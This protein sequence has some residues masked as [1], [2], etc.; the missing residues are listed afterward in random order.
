MRASL[1]QDRGI[2]PVIG[3]ILML[4]ITVALAMFAASFFLGL[5][6]ETDPQP[7]VV[8][9]DADADDT[10]HRL[11]HDGG[12]TLDGDRLELQGALNPDAAAGKRLEDGDEI[13][14]YPI[15]E[16]ITVVWH[17]DNDE[18]YQLTTLTVE[19]AL[20]EPDEGCEWVEDQTNG[21]TDPI[22]I[23]DKVVNCDVQTADQIKVRN[24]GIVI[25]ETLS[26]NKDLDIDAGEVYGDATIETVIDVQDGRIRGDTTSE[27]A[28]VK[29]SNTVVEGTVSSDKGTE[30]LDGSTVEDSVTAGGTIDV[31]DGEI[32]GAATSEDEDV[33]LTNAV[34][35]EEIAAGKVIDVQDSR[36]GGPATSE[37]K[38]VTFTNAVAEGGVT[39]ETVVDL[40]DSQIGGPATSKT[41]NVKLSNT[42]AGGGVTAEKTA[43]VLDGTTVD[44]SVTAKKGAT[45]DDGTVTGDVESTGEGTDI[46]SGSVVEGSVT[47]NKIVEVDGSTIEGH[48][49]AEP[50]DFKCTDSTINGEDCGSYDP[51]DPD[52]W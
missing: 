35:E 28:N 51:K 3:A 18:S 23:D 6:D 22:T 12:E 2:S 7:N 8:L 39:A 40:Q 47:A 31:Q 33:K 42:T 25:G 27:T 5:T 26:D 32:G 36:I 44:G 48:V 37:T 9:S 17:G 14:F 46:L 4:A 1:P 15:S 52:D 19:Q 21:G 41:E 13:E 45:V 43:D 50:S 10:T 24:D 29:L 30:V 11:I 34:V 49:Y 38:S 20:P 16:E